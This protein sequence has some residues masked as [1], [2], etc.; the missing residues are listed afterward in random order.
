MN[1]MFRLNGAMLSSSVNTV[2]FVTYKFLTMA[3]HE[4]Y[5]E[6]SQG[7]FPLS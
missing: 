6:N 7:Q 4:Q 2:F 1:Y 3:V 5:Q